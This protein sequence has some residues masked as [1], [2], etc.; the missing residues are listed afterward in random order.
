MVDYLKDF[1]IEL[2][3]KKIYNILGYSNG[4]QP[5]PSICSL[6]DMEMAEARELIRTSCFYQI[7][8]I[9]RI[10]RPRVTLVNGTKATFTSEVLSWALYPCEQAVIFVASIG[11]ALE[12]RVAQ[13]TSEGQSG[14]AYILD[15]IGSE[16]TEK[17][18]FYLQDQ[19]RE[20]AK[21]DDGET[22]LRYSPGY[23]DWDISQ[24][25]VLFE[26]M[27]STPLQVSLS[28]QCLMTPRKSVSGIIGLGWKEKPR[29]RL[30][31]CRFCSRQDCKNRR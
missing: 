22:T 24:Q 30:P 21:F 9:Q 23:C 31:P 15:T 14:K 19:I 26:A 5:K 3:A 20:V 12:Q 2:D 1:Q 7:M 16:A 4:H 13:L 18:V 28:H 6:V 10:R 11:P 25:R 17:T 8:D 27:G 29:L